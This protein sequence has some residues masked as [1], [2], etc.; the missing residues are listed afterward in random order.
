MNNIGIA[1]LLFS[2]DHYEDLMHKDIKYF[3]QKQ[4]LA[5]HKHLVP[6]L[7]G[8]SYEVNSSV[9]LRFQCS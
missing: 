8:L 9:E 1:M 7:P 5:D 2:C 4:H 6:G 3:K